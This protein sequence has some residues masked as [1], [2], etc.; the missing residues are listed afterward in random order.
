MQSAQLG[1]IIFLIGWS[2]T[3]DETIVR[4]EAPRLYLATTFLKYVLWATV[5]K[6]IAV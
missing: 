2:Y 1:L 4:Q 3:I 5:V 6:D